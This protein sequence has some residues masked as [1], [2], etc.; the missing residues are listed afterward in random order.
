MQSIKDKALDYRARRAKENFPRKTV[1]YSEAKRV[2]L[3]FKVSDEDRH[4]EVNYFV[5]KLEKE[6]KQVEALT[7]F[8]R[9]HDNP[10][11]FKYGFFTDKDISV[12]GEI[13]SETVKHF[14]EKEFDFLFCISRE[15]ILAFD[16]ILAKSRAKCRVGKYVE[17]TEHL[18]ELMIQSKP[19]EG[20]A[21]F[22][23]DILDFIKHLKSN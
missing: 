20:I 17:G 8:T 4:D 21:K 5:H 13:K 22:A 11:D 10:Y 9:D 3:L 6:G 15:K 2:G 14:I 18:Y 1:N 23:D 16:L 19:E 7:Y 12:L